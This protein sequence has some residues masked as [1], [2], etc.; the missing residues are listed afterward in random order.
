[1]R[2][3]KKWAPLVAIFAI[4]ILSAH[5]ENLA[6]A[7]QCAQLDLLFSKKIPTL[8]SF[9][10]STQAGAADLTAPPRSIALWGDSLTSTRDFMDAALKVA[11]ISTVTALPS[12]IQAGM[13]VPGLRLPL[14][15]ACASKGW[16]TAYAHKQKRDSSGFSKGFVSLSSE[17][18]GAT[19]SLDFRFP[20][21]STRVKQLTLLYEKPEPDASLLLGVSVDDGDESLISLSKTSASVLQIRPTA[22]MAAI[23][24]RLVSGKMTV[25]G[26][27]PS[28]QEAPAAI[29]DTFSVP[30]GLLRGWSYMNERLF[31]ATPEVAANY[32]TVLVQYGT[33]EGANTDFSAAAYAGYLRTN[34]S[35]M[36]TFFPRSRCILIGPPDRGVVGAAAQSNP[37]KYS[38]IHRQIALAQKQVGAEY[39][40]EF[41]DW[42]AAMGGPGSALRWARMNTPQMQQDLTHLTAKGYQISG[43][44]FAESLLLN[45]Y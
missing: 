7:P 25:H 9:T 41:W 32:S 11:G 40:C 24:I 14:K 42:Q 31:T 19:I 29:L 39:R 13:A 4:G 26:F 2:L 6:A 12:F 36:R 10:W 30:G 22:P 33:N 5:A 17:N 27:A 34:L 44:M 35:R 21:P 43:Q 18:P 3:I 8:A 15:A 16:Q 38:T 28:Y 45:K 37:L 23:K 1:M 20:T